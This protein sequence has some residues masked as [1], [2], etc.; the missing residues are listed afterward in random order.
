MNILNRVRTGLKL[1]LSVAAATVLV[2]VALPGVAG[3]H[4]PE[5]EAEADCV[6]FVIRYTAEAWVGEPGVLDSRINNDVR[7]F[8]DGVEVGSGQFNAA[9]N[10]TFSGEVPATP[11]D[12]IVVATSVVQW[13][14]NMDRGDSGETR[15][16]TVFVPE[17]C[18]PPT[19][20]PPTTAPPTTAPPVVTT[21]TTT[22]TTTTVPT[23]VEGEVEV[24]P[25]AQ[26]VP[27]QPSFTG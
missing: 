21:P 13:G 11:G 7:I 1:G 14:A 4:H 27:G 12:H 18:V 6:A 19:T 2:V 20:A 17:D 24:S 26:P 23:D 5:I 3:A 25:P 16:T 15:Q 9:N 22:T 8:L 10:Y